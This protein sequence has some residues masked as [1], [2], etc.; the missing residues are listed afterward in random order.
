MHLYAVYTVAVS[1]LYLRRRLVI[2]RV[3][4]LLRSRATRLQLPVSS[5]LGKWDRF[6]F[7]QANAVTRNDVTL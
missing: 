2:L 5:A 6:N 3:L 7:Q 4:M 1:H